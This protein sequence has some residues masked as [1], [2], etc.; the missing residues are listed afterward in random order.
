MTTP[1]R[2]HVTD[3]GQQA[4][5]L[6]EQ[7]GRIAGTIEGTAEAWLNRQSLTEQL[8]RVRDGAAE[9]LESLT[10]GAA[11]GRRA[12]AESAQAVT[13][14]ARRAAT[15][16]ASTATSMATA[17]VESARRARTSVTTPSKKK[18]NRGRATTRKT[19]AADPAHAPGKRHK[20]PP[21]KTVRGRK[22]DVRI[23]NMKVAEAN[24][25]RRPSHA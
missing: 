19:A 13:E 3:L 7:L 6:A 14:Q 4:I 2:K 23:A 5:A 22:S 21:K 12:A 24:R 10:N 9:M 11:R 15:A 17:A 20:K 18:G 25:R 8:T 16:A 1:E